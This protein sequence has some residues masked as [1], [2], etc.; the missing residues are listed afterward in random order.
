V[1]RSP[2]RRTVRIG[3]GCQAV[4]LPSGWWHLR[5]YDPARSPKQ[6][7]H[8]LDTDDEAVALSRARQHWDRKLAGLYDP[9]KGGGRPLTVEQACAVYE[10]ERGG[11]LRP[12]SIRL[13]TH[14]LRSLAASTGRGWAPGEEGTGADPARV[15]IRDVTADHVR[16]YVY[17]PGLSRTSHLSY[18]RRLHAAFEWA[19]ESQLV[20]ENPVVSVARPPDPEAG[21]KYLTEDE[22]D[23]LF[24]TIEC[25]HGPD[26]PIPEH[27][28]VRDL[29]PL[30]ARDAFELLAATG[31]RRGEGIELRWGD[32]VFPEASPWGVGFVKVV[33]EGRAEGRRT[34]TGRSRH[35][36]MIPR[37]EAVLR[38]LHATTRRTDRDDEH[39]LKGATGRIPVS[40]HTLS[41][42]FKKYRELA[43]LPDV[44]LHGLR[45][46]F[47]VDL[48]LR[49]A[50]L[51]QVRD[52]LGHASVKTTERYLALLPA[53]RARATS[54]LFG[55]GSEDL[56]NDLRMGTN[57]YEPGPAPRR[58]NR[59]S[60]P[61]NDRPTAPSASSSSASATSAGARSPRGSSSRR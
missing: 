51:I 24:Q 21:L 25:H 2:K 41:H 6:K 49:G 59:A 3:R 56:P 52:E 18:W 40:P 33:D 35:V 61:K 34:K 22:V 15:A 58:P 44:P 32:V 36:T 19:R 57:G 60:C 27:V 14:A 50:S 31:L 17:R 48:L 54:R 12:N 38:R 13:T 30:W 26:G 8:A 11:V 28:R 43:G 1:S 55:K 47:A 5:W 37:A 7:Q 23:H 42:N 16:R 45:H 39:V 10:R 46:S 20:D 29:H 9:W 53:E 4:R